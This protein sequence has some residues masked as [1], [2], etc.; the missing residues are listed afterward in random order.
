MAAPRTQVTCTSTFD[1][2]A[3]V[4]R[5]EVVDRRGHPDLNDLPDNPTADG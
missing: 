5:H 4:L 1:D 3:A 2:P